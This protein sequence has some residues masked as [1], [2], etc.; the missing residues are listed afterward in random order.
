MEI[1]PTLHG[2]QF[3]SIADRIARFFL[4]RCARRSVRDA[5]NATNARRRYDEC[6]KYGKTAFSLDR[7]SRRTR[8]GMK[9]INIRTRVCARY[10]L[11]IKRGERVFNVAYI[12]ERYRAQ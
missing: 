6:F 8:A 11:E 2:E 12:V 5:C 9:Q 1:P 3:S 4:L 10:I 7:F